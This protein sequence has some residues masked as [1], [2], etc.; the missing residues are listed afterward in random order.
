[1]GWTG[2]P[3]SGVSVQEILPP[4][5]KNPDYQGGPAKPTTSIFTLQ[6]TNSKFVMAQMK[7]R[8]RVALFVLD[9]VGQSIPHK[10]VDFRI[11]CVGYMKVYGSL[12]TATAAHVCY[13][14]VIFN[15][16]VC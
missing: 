16:Y 8:D 4:I 5:N 13:F 6:W 10:S 3:F 1:M 12:R 2:S 9:S 11:V 7:G 14:L 15:S